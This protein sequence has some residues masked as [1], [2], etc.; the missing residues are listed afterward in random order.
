MSGS[1]ESVTQA[2]RRICVSCTGI[3]DLTEDDD[4]VRKGCDSLTAAEVIATIEIEFGE[5]LVLE[6]FAR[7]TIRHLADELTRRATAQVDPAE[8]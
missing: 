6:F 2:V 4:L 1:D 3:A 7:P 5:D 8:V